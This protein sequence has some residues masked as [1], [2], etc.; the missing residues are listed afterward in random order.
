MLYHVIKAVTQ[1]LLKSCFFIMPFENTWCIRE[2]AIAN[3]WNTA[4]PN[5]RKEKLC[6]GT[7]Y[8]P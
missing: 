1:L 2:L 3:K 5:K 4:N 7:L 8:M 6:K